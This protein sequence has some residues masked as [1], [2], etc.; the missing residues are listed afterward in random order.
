MHT[1]LPFCDVPTG[2][3]NAVKVWMVPGT[4]NSSRQN[5]LFADGCCRDVTQSSERHT[6]APAK[7]GQNLFSKF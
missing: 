3:Q 4:Q 7:P 2:E 5:N 1:H 6:K